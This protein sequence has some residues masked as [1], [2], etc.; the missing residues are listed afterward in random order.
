[1]NINKI[2]VLAALEA[3]DNIF[4]DKIIRITMRDSNNQNWIRKKVLITLII[5]KE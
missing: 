3:R 2:L 1:M 4:G 5:G